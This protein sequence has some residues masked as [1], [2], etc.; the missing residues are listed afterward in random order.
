MYKLRSEGGVVRLA[1]GAQIPENDDNADW[2]RFRAWRDAGNAP[3]PADGPTAIDG[4][5]LLDKAEFQQTR[6]QAGLVALL[7]MTPSEQSDWVDARLA[8]GEQAIVLRTLLRLVIAI[9]RHMMR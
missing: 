6:Q 2:R 9:A 3:E 5:I 1:D 8:A 7:N 4:R